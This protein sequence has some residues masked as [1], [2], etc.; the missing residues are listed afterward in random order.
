MQKL[1]FVLVFLVALINLNAQQPLL[2]NNGACMLMNPGSFMIVKNGSVENSAGRIANAGTF[3]IEGNYVNSD[4]TTGNASNTGLFDI[5]GNWENNFLFD[6]DQS[7]VQLSGG[8]QLITGNSISVFYNLFLK[9]NLTKRQTINAEVSNVLD[10]D[11]TELA[12]DSFEMLVSNSSSTAILRNN[13]FVSSLGLGRLSRNT[14]STSSYLFPTGSNVGTFRYRPVELTP[15]NSDANT[16]GV[17][18]ANVDPTSEN[19]DRLTKEDSLC[20][21]NPLYYHRIYR[22]SGNT[23]VTIAYFYDALA[24]NNW[25]VLA[26]WKNAPQWENTST[27]SISNSAPF[28]VLEIDNWDDFSFSPFALA[29]LSPSVAA[30]GSTQIFSG[31]SAPLQGI[32]NNAVT[33]YLWTPSFGLDCADC[34]NPLAT[35]DSTTIYTLTVNSGSICERSDTV[36]VEVINKFNLFLPNAFS[37]N[38]DQENDVFKLFGN[39]ESI[40]T[41][42]LRIFDR[43]G[44]KV[45]E[46]NDVESAINGWDGTFFDKV[47]D[48]GV[49]VYHVIITFKKAIRNPY[50]DKGSLVLLK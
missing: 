28:D 4:T 39:T 37:P 47:L 15:N 11:N 1:L 29:N 41:I 10:L 18:L 16:F 42:H 48:P 43:W 2:F 5:L 32:G 27:A 3:I 36:L 22:G 45:F 7:T 19:F 30:L 49:F 26:Q 38:N 34:A 20:E 35:P 44:E 31:E 23:P 14:N 25:S 17:R 12:T 9:G 33:D 8:N 6:A 21:I 40:S 50:E 13:G 24:D 46:A